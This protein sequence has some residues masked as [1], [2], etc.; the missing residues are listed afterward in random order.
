[1][2]LLG[3]LLIH[4]RKLFV[5]REKGNSKIL[6]IKGK[7]TYKINLHVLLRNI[8]DENQ[9]HKHSTQAT[10]PNSYLRQIEKCSICS[11]NL[12]SIQKCKIQKDVLSSLRYYIWIRLFKKLKLKNWN[13]KLFHYH[14]G[15]KYAVLL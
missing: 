5:Y 11:P 1:M 9:L 4:T 12:L 7:D 2:L 13:W 3:V 10:Y 14:F 6:Q 8:L 15:K